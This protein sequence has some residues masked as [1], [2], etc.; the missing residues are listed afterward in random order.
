MCA[1]GL[2]Q[3]PPPPQVH[4]HR[5]HTNN[6]GTNNRPN[7]GASL[8]LSSSA[9]SESARRQTQSS[10]EN[11]GGFELG[12]APSSNSSTASA[13]STY[14]SS[15]YSSATSTSQ[16]QST[17]AKDVMQHPS[18]SDDSGG[19][20]PGLPEA[21][22]APSPLPRRPKLVRRQ[23]SLSEVGWHAT[24][25]SLTSAAVLLF[26]CYFPFFLAPWAATQTYQ[27][28]WYQ[29]DPIRSVFCNSIWTYGTDYFLAAAM[30]LLASRIASHNPASRILALR[31]RGL[32]ICYCCSVLAGGVAH[33]YYTTLQSRNTWHFRFLWTICVGSVTVASAWMG[34]LGT[35]LARIDRTAD[36][37]VAATRGI[38]LLPE[39]FWAAYGTGATIAC[40]AGSMS[41]Q[42]PACDMYVVSLDCRCEGSWASF[43]SPKQ[44]VTHAP[45]LCFLHL[46]FSPLICFA[47]SLLALRNFR[48]RSTSCCC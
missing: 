37:G 45:L 29:Y 8:E 20:S 26:S 15:S 18:Y 27:P 28:A 33:Q 2:D 10:L 16:K 3:H 12:D 9:S 21:R 19:T 13:S 1:A 44:N 38:P 43:C 42:R 41:F 23:T 6:N 35:E 17:M 5:N 31:S 14:S 22:S 30:A 7:G 34:C 25:G 24:T 39:W 36:G 46:P 4:K 40:A 48:P 32:L 11:S 47:A